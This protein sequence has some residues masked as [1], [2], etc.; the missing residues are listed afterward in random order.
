MQERES[1]SITSR[2]ELLAGISHYCQQ[3]RIDPPKY[4]RLKIERLPFNIGEG[5]RKVPYLF[6]GEVAETISSSLQKL[7]GLIKKRHERESRSPFHTYLSLSTPKTEK[8]VLERHVCIRDLDARP[9]EKRIAE[10]VIYHNPYLDAGIVGGW[11]LQPKE[12]GRFIGTVKNLYLKAIAEEIKRGGGTDIT[13]LTHLC[14]VAYL[15]KAKETLKKVNIKGFSYEKLE[16]TVSQIL[17]STIKQIQAKVFD[18]IRYK[19]LSFD[20]TRLEYLI[21]G[22]TNPLIFV[23]IRPTLFKNDLNPYHLDQEGF[24]FLQ[25]LFQKVDMDLQDIE[26]SLR[27]LVEGAK[28]DKRVR[29]KLIELW[30]INRFREAVFHYLKDYEEYSRDTDLQLFHLFQSNKLIKS[31]LTEEEAGKRLE[32]DL[33]KLISEDTSSLDKERIQR[34][35]AIENSFKSHKKGRILKKLFFGSREEEQ[36]KEVIEGFLLYQLDDRWT[37]WIEESLQRLEDREGLKRR[38]ELEEEY[39]RGRIYRFAVDARPILQDLTVRKEGHL[40]MDLRGFTQR[41][42][43]SKEITMADF[44]LKGFF[45][46]VL[47]VAKKYY[48]NEGVRLN[49]L[50]GDALSFS[51]KIE[52][53]VSLAQNL[54]EIFDKYT[55]KMKE[56]GGLL[57][58]EDEVRAIEERYRREKMAIIQERKAIEE[59]IRGIERELKVKEFLNPVYL[60]KVQE[61][62]FDSKL[63]HYQREIISLTKKMEIEEDPHRRRILMDLKKGLLAL[64]EGIS[65]HKKELT[66]NISLIGGGELKEVF[67]LVCSEEREE[68]ERLRKL[69]KE[70]YDK[71]LKLIRAYEKEIA[72]L[73]DE[74]VEY[75]LFI[76]YGNAAETIAFEDEFW[77]KVNVA[78]A[79][80]LNEAAR[81]AERNP[82][83][84]RKLDLL[85][86]NA[87][88]AR[89][90]PSLEYP[91]Y[92]FIDKSYGLSLRSDLSTKVEIALRGEDV[93]TAREVVEATSSSLMHDI[94]RGMRG[95]GE[96]DWEVLTPLND[97]YNLGEAMSEEA[98]QAYLRETSPYR[99]HFE[100]EVNTSEIHPEIQKRCFFPSAELKL[101]I[102]VER[103][104]DRLRFDLFRYVGELVFKGFETHKATAV[105]EIVR[106]DSSLYHLLE[107]YHLMAW[108]KEAREKMRGMRTAEG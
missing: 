48:T 44:M 88:W 28:K 62:E 70:S 95:Y 8:D 76:S 42:S 100:K 6:D 59:S 16:Q 35:M 67:R 10:D 45:L 83:T 78:I 86:R 69:L 71:E 34:V 80:K 84:R 108:Y 53:L 85:L 39:E 49:N 61:E 32:E 92:V 87:R 91:F 97:I 47:L 96:D 65:E 56:R 107:R 9:L 50:L 17:Y 19:D 89:G 37:R 1:K 93:E 79:D 68:L 98:L 24:E 64:R 29:E 26:G 72:S 13:Y 103:N 25:T 106:K 20:V 5:K 14:L 3:K 82:A 41:M 54:R 63:F 57:G 104:G 94:E 21:K 40:F 30:S 33:A 4:L 27:N 60:L 11:F 15:K 105:Y 51:G 2:L 55:K 58:E 31:T 74:E 52:S 101:L 7:V 73:K 99:Y 38:D 75:G 23:A 22:S 36:L 66:E 18:E 90:N 46:P 102:S 43:R 12:V 81:G 77:G